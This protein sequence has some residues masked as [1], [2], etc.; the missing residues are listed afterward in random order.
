MIPPGGKGTV[1]LT[2]HTKT[3][4]GAFKKYALVYTNDPVMK[5]FKLT[6]KGEVIPLVRFEPD[7]AVNFFGVAGTPFEK[8]LTVCPGQDRPLF[9]KKVS[10]DIPKMVGYELGR[11]DNGCYTLRIIN[12]LKEPGSYHGRLDIHTGY[13]EKK[14]FQVQVTAL[15]APKVEVFPAQL[16]LGKLSRKNPKESRRVTV[17]SNVGGSIT[18]KEISYNRKFFEVKVDESASQNGRLRLT[19]VLDPAALPA[20]RFREPL[21]LS[22]KERN[23]DPVKITVVGQVDE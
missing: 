5:R 6:L 22:F 11:A 23:L 10:T 15:I 4:S 3:L 14:V 20:G 21:V 13:L 16:V 1:T 17:S 7:S 19:V 12:K 9:I 2:V 8:T 18:V